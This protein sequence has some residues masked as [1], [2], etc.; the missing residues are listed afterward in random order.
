MLEF[1]GRLD[2]QVKLGGYRIELAE[3]EAAVLAAGQAEACVAALRLGDDGTARLVAILAAKPGVPSDDLVARTRSFLRDRLPP[4]AIPACFQVVSEI[5]VSAHGK[6]DA[7]AL[8]DGVSGSEPDRAEVMNGTTEL[9]LDLAAAV[10]GRADVAPSMNFFASG[11][12]SLAAIDLCRRLSS[13]IGREVP[14]RLAFEAPSLADMAASIDAFVRR[15]P[16]ASLPPVTKARTPV[17]ASHAQRRLLAAAQG[18]AAGTQAITPLPFRLAPPVDV[19]ALRTALE[20]VVRRHPTLRSVFHRGADGS[21]QVQPVDAAPVMSVTDL[22]T[23]PQAGREAGM[24]EACRAAMAEKRDLGREPPMRAILFLDPP[25]GGILVLLLDHLTYDAR[26]IAV[27]S[28]DIMDFYVRAPTERPGPALSFLDYAAWEAERERDGTIGRLTE[29]AAARAATAGRRFL[30]PVHNAK[31]AK[32][33]Y[34]RLLCGG[35]QFRALARRAGTTVFSA[36]LARTLSALNAA[37][38][39]PALRLAVQTSTRIDRRLFDA[40]GPFM[41]TTHIDIEMSP[42]PMELARRVQRELLLAQDVALVPTGLLRSKLASCGISSEAVLP[43]VLFALQQQEGG[44]DPQPAGRITPLDPLDGWDAGTFLTGY[45]AI[46][47]GTLDQGGLTFRFGLH[48]DVADQDLGGRFA[49]AL[50]LSSPGQLPG[51]A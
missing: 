8:L 11:G 2:R 24:H 29:F 44:P 36:V 25:R 17:P 28:R 31:P 7:S 37:Q 21:L 27:I 33:T 43:D 9:L 50:A 49:A 5:P 30:P 34:A 42:D 3:V 18:A 23:R 41:N 4:Y 16:D 6:I 45:A 22:G 1:V 40:V 39:T 20:A 10:L 38:P 35:A 51:N 13:V 15:S 12:H 26:S 19:D 32:I 48:P 46:I 47:L 14:M